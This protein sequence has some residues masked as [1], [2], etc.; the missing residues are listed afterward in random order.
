ME[1][2]R[3]IGHLCP[4]GHYCVP[5]QCPPGYGELGSATGRQTTTQAL[6]AP[7]AIAA[8]PAG[9]CVHPYPETAA[10]PHQARRKY[11]LDSDEGHQHL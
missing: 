5:Q 11:L 6:L 7:R 2:N 1:L 10:A 9:P 4:P 3:Q 8:R